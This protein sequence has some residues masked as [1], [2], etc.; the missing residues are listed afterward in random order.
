MDVR[1]Q[2]NAIALVAAGDDHQWADVGLRKL[3]IVAGLSRKDASLKAMEQIVTPWSRTR[4]EVGEAPGLLYLGEH[5]RDAR[6]AFDTAQV[7]VQ[8]RKF[9]TRALALL[10]SFD[11]HIPFSPFSLVLHS[12]RPPYRGEASRSALSRLRFRVGGNLNNAHDVNGFTHLG[13]R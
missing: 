9:R 10:D 1:A 7:P 6:I 3:N 8:R 11:H 5:L 2:F 13:A 12:L 4:A